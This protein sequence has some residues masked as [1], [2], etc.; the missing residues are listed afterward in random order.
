[1]PDQ[2]GYPTDEELATVREWPSTNIHG[3][4]D[5]LHSLWWQPEYGWRELE[6]REGD[7]KTRHIFASTGGWSG[8]EDLMSAFRDNFLAYHQAFNSYRRGGH[9]ELVIPA[10]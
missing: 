5:Y 8:N 2:D 7:D 3:L 6:G 9:Y 1:M 10:R 4:L